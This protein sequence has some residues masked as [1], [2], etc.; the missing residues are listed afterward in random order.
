MG[1]PARESMP[2]STNEA[3][4]RRARRPACSG[5]LALCLALLTPGPA[6]AAGPIRVTGAD[7]LGDLPT[8]VADRRGLFAREGLDVQ[9]DYGVSGRD[10]LRALREGRTDFALM[11]LTPLVLDHLRRGPA[12]H[13]NDPVMLASMVHS[14]RLNHLVAHP[15]SDIRGAAD[16]AGRRVGLVADTHAAFAWSL[17]A[18]YHDRTPAGARVVRREPAALAD[19]LASG[20]LP[21]A[22]LWQ[23]W[24]QRVEQRIGEPLRRLEYG[25]LYAA[26][27]VLVTR[28]AA[29]TE[30]PRRVE[31]LLRAYRA[32]IRRIET[33]PAPALA[34]YAQHAGIEAPLD[35]EQWR[36]LDYDLALD[37]S[38]IASVQQQIAWA[39]R[40]GRVASGR[41][42]DVLSL[43]ADTPLR[44][45][46][47]SAVGIPGAAEQS[48]P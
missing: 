20:A 11:A 33:D 24:I 14:R 37:W 2:P 18:D 36:T 34:L 47:P 44:N 46:D 32:A 35:P 28:R 25:D 16:L 38:L 15:D 12:R 9:V 5:L 41:P 4:T 3:G 26:H 42:T 19:A 30:H 48:R 31:R 17:Y 13:A 7:Y 43:F 21:A 22:L 1:R 40:S 6:M 39:R 29:V 8:L 45:I 10:N 23:P 27:W